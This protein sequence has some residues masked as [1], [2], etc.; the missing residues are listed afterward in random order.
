MSTLCKSDIVYFQDVMN[1]KRLLTHGYLRKMEGKFQSFHA[2]PTA[3]KHMILKYFLFNEFEFNRSSSHWAISD[4]NLQA[5]LE[6]DKYGTIQ[7][8]QF[9]KATDKVIYSVTFKITGAGVHGHFGIGFITSKF[10]QWNPSG[11]N[12]EYGASWKACVTMYGNGYYRASNPFSELNSQFTNK[13]ALRISPNDELNVEINTMT[14]K[15]KVSCLRNK[16]ILKSVEINLPPEVAIIFTAG[17]FVS[18][19]KAMKQTLSYTKK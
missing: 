8:G 10:K 16:E 2:I 9:L 19:I 12:D 13:T 18:T 3:L 14:M 15:G 6:Q 5:S 17:Y 7:F 4:D 11:F 1:S